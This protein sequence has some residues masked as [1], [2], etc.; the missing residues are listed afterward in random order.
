[1]E[2]SDLNGRSLGISRKFDRL[3]HHSTVAWAGLLD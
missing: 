1:M 3:R 2:I